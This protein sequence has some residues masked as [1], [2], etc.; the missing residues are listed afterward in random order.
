MSSEEISAHAIEYCD[1][2]EE[3]DRA[4]EEMKKIKKRKNDLARTIIKSLGKHGRKQANVKAKGM[5]LVSHEDE[6]GGSMSK[7]LLNQWLGMLYENDKSKVKSALKMLEKLR[8]E[9][10]QKRQRLCYKRVVQREGRLQS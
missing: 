6:V 9:N 2:I 5:V 4:K 10:R 8:T 1:V 3:E 7:N